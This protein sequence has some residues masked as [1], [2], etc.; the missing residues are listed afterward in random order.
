[1]SRYDDLTDFQ[2]EDDL[3]TLD[4]K[5]SA[6]IDRRSAG[7]RKPAARNKPP[8]A[9]VIPGLAEAPDRSGEFNFT[10]KASRHEAV[11]LNASLGGF[12]EDQWVEDVLQM[13]KGGKEAS[14]YLCQSNLDVIPAPLAAAKVYRPRMLR[15]LKRDHE[16]REGRADLDSDGRQIL[17]GGMLH[18]ISKRSAYG[19]E[20]RH[21]SWIEYEFQTLTALHAAGADSPEPYARANNA[22]LMEY[23][24]DED[25]PAP[26]LNTV[27]LSRSEARS[28]FERVLRN[29]D[30]LLTHNR[31]HGDLSAYNILYWDGEIT[32][33][34]FPQV[35]DPRTNHQAYRIFERDVTRICEYFAGQGLRADG[36]RLAAQIWQ[37]HGQRID[38]EVHPAFLDAD[39]P[40]D[41]KAWLK[42][43]ARK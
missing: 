8:A 29:I 3:D 5:F 15:A 23:I 27:D 14:V 38:P 11:W 7:G 40:Q 4:P 13:V 9:A 30:L 22:I 10:Y 26:T 37:A 31:V 21:S 35:I 6:R 2:I 32:L 34:D 41:R 42:E 12:Y 16:Y 20:L 36:R 39:D 28:L 1:M 17:D 33:I 19:Q 24:G 43:S 25:G 18:A